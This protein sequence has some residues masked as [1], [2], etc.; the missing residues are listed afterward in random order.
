[1][2]TSIGESFRFRPWVAD[3]G[4]GAISRVSAS[5]DH[6]LQLA[7]ANDIKPAAQLSQSPQYGLVRIRLDGDANKVIHLSHCAVLVAR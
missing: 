6:S 4:K 7:T 2:M 1:M 5:I 3:A